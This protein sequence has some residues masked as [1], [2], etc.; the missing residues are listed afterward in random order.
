M[1]ADIA[2][3]F[4]KSAPISVYFDPI[5]KP[6]WNISRDYLNVIPCTVVLK[7]VFSIIQ[8]PG[9]TYSAIES[10]TNSIYPQID[11]LI[12]FKGFKRDRFQPIKKC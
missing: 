10:S 3:K 2:N 4:D 12:L 8:G 6:Q 9:I 7:S 5:Y 11:W 1:P